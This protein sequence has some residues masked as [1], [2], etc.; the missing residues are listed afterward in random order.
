ML[1]FCLF[2]VVH[3]SCSINHTVLRPEHVLH[4][5]SNP[6]P[7]IYCATNCSTNSAIWLPKN[8]IPSNDQSLFHDVWSIKSSV[9]KHIFLS[10]FFVKQ[11]LTLMSLSTLMSRV[12]LFS[13]TFL[14]SIVFSRKIK[15]SISGLSQ[16]ISL[17]LH[18]KTVIFSISNYRQLC[19]I[20]IGYIT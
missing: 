11:L 15:S 18:Y 5:D 2:T 4:Q 14:L 10:I 8:I 9:S 1:Q 20:P 16:P 19:I 6:K 13:N 17:L 3:F 7:F 12:V